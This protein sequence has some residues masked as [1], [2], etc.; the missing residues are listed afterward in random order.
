[1]KHQCLQSCD[2]IVA[3][4][5]DLEVRI[6]RPIRRRQDW[7]QTAPPSADVKRYA[8]LDTET[9]GLD[10]LRHSIIEICVAIIAVDNGGNILALERLGSGLQDPGRPLSKAVAELT[11]L[12]NDDLVNQVID[13][14]NL[15]SFIRLADGCIAFNSAF[16]RPML[17]NLLPATSS[18]KW[19]CAMVDVDWRGAGFQPGAQNFLLMQAGYHNPTAHRARDDVLSLIQLLAHTFSDG[20]AV[21]SQVTAAMDEPS[22]RFEATDAPYHE[23]YNLKDQRYRWSDKNKVWHKLVRQRDYEAELA[24]YE[25]EIG[26]SPSVISVSAE[27]RYRADYTWRAHHQIKLPPL[28]EEPTGHPF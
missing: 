3:T 22:W 1:M 12:A 17:E 27:E 6:I 24:W 10:P 5:N 7:P 26:R 19:G 9:N 8:V 2:E 18:M 20:T 13:R 28:S 21:L 15:L 23:R 16:D 14:D 25:T 11:G 4:N